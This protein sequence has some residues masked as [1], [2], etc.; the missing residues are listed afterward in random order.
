MELMRHMSMSAMR[1]MCIICASVIMSSV[2][3]NPRIFAVMGND[4]T[5]CPNER[6]EHLILCAFI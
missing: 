1:Q 6:E 2:K 5:L 4:I 3:W